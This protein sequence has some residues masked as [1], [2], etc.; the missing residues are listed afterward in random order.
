MGSWIKAIEARALIIHQEL[1]AARELA[2]RMGQEPDVISGPYLDMLA[3][4]Y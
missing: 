2:V 3:K 1:Q 4:L